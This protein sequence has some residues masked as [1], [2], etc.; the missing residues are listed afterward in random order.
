MTGVPSPADSWVSR[1][2]VPSPEGCHEEIRG[3]GFCIDLDKRTLYHNSS[4]LEKE[5]MPLL[6]LQVPENDLS[7]VWSWCSSLHS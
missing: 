1:S 7:L 3:I 2:G 5:E 6:L 4:L